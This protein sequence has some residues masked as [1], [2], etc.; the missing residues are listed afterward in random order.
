MV[1]F[2]PPTPWVVLN[3]F[4]RIKVGESTFIKAPATLLARRFDSSSPESEAFIHDPLTAL[5]ADARSGDD[6]VGEADARQI[7]GLI[8]ADW[9]VSTLVANHQATLSIKHLHAV[10]AVIPSNPSVGIMLVKQPAKP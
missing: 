5:M 3:D 9:H 4:D 10:V 6:L 2:E 1:T 8:E 7:L